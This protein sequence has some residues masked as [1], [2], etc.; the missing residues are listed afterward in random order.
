MRFCPTGRLGHTVPHTLPWFGIGSRCPRSCH[1][2]TVG[3]PAS[4]CCSTISG[5][6]SGTHLP[7][8]PGNK[9]LE[10]NKCRE[11]W[12]S[13]MSMTAKELLFGDTDWEWILPSPPTVWAWS[14]P[15]WASISSTIKA[16]KKNPQVFFSKVAQNIHDYFAQ[17]LAYGRHTRQC[18]NEWVNKWIKLSDTKKLLTCLLY[19]FP[20]FPNLA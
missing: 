7:L 4:P 11:S 6:N 10:Q 1:T 18:R 15:L 2:R 17:Y 9:G 5:C 8:D 13:C 3:R 20:S 12:I 16:I 14:Y 19:S